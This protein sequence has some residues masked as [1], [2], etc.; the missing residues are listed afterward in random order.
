MM[1][2]WYAIFAHSPNNESERVEGDVSGPDFGSFG[3]AARAAMIGNR[4]VKGMWVFDSESEHDDALAI[5]GNLPGS[6]I[7][8]ISAR[9]KRFPTN[10]RRVRKKP[11]GEGGARSKP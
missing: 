6:V 9:T 7:E 1:R 11:A 8:K 2:E 4:P 5:Y 10:R 3:V